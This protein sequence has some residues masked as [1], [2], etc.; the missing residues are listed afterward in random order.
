L[1]VATICALLGLVGPAGAAQRVTIS[2]RFSPYKLGGSAAMQLGMTVTPASGQVPS[3]L[4]AIDFRYPASLGIATSGLGTATC[5]P[6]VLDERGPE[7]C[8][9]DSIMGNGRALARFRVGPEI[10]D[11]SASI[12]IVAGP[13]PDGRLRLL[14]GA[15]GLDPVVARIV[16]ESTLENGHFAVKVPLVPSLPEGEDVAVT[17][18]RVTLGG[19][20]TYTERRNGRTVRYTPKGVGI[21]R[22]CPR[23]GFRFSGRFEFADGSATTAGTAIACPRRR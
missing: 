6:L 12:G 21:P 4:T 11:E 3:P 5:T 23:G 7:G 13:S 15:T 10:F 18:V 1:G 2:A 17:S 22:R 14:I 19:R 20:L 8:P 16:M 9:K